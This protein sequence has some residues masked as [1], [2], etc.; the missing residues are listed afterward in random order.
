M[1]KHSPESKIMDKLRFIS[2]FLVL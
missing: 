2:F 1:H